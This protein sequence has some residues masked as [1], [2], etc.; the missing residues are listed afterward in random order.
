MTS[1]TGSVYKYDISAKTWTDITPPSLVGDQIY[2]FGGFTVDLQTGTIMTAALNLWWPDAQIFRSNDTGS[3]WST[4][5]TWDSPGVSV[6]CVTGSVH[7]DS[8]LIHL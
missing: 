5:W 6:K 8:S 3:T 1:F 7:L 4:L 2:G